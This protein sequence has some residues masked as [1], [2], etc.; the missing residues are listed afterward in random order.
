V[1]KTKT[2][3]KM[4]IIQ[5][6]IVCLINGIDLINTSWFLKDSGISL[7]GTHLHECGL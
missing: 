6:E 2:D 4:I 5:S 7:C 3:L 1:R